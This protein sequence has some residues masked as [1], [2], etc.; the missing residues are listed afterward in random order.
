MDFEHPLL[1]EVFKNEQ[2]SITSD[3]MNVESPK[4]KSYYEIIKGDNAGSIISLNNK[5]DFLIETKLGDGKIIISSVPASLNYSNF[6]LKSLFAPLIIRSV[7]YL[8]NNYDYQKE[9][10]VGEINIINTRNLGPVSEITT[11]SGI[12]VEYI[13]NVPNGDYF[14]LPYD[15]NTNEAG[16]YTLLDSAG[17][18]FSFSLNKS[19]EESIL[20]KE[21]E[22]QILNYFRAKGFDNAGIISDS[23]ELQFKIN[24]ARTGKDLSIFFLLAS[25]ACVLAELFLSKK[26]QES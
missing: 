22:S 6:P 19:S 10:T 4:I 3:N 25:I 24:E 8:G 7:F 18:K 11:P 21:V 16:I 1:S 13:E 26:M 15:I 14:T 17:N 23:E 12:S 5:R 20:E 2:L 9:Y